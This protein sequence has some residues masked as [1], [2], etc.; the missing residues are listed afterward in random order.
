MSMIGSI[1]ETVEIRVQELLHAVTGRNDEQDRRL[2]ALEKRVA[3]L[4]PKVPPAAKKTTA[5]PPS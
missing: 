4:E 2:D 5:R 3:D 1:L